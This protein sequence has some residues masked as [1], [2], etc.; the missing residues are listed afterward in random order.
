MKSLSFNITPSENET[1]TKVSKHESLEKLQKALWNLRTRI[2]QHVESMTPLRYLDAIKDALHTQ[3]VLERR[4]NLVQQQL[5]ENPNEKSSSKANV[6]IELL[7]RE[8]H[9]LQMTIRSITQ[10]PIS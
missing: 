1:L 5:D 3:S 6:E 8:I 9:L 2:H 10:N 7:S 4:L